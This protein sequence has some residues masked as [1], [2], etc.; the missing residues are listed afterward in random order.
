MKAKEA[1]I[2]IEYCTNQYNEELMNWPFVYAGMSAASDV[3]YLNKMPLN[4][5]YFSALYDFISMW[6][7][8]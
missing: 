5:E 1:N 4:W 8:H 2:M 6:Q 3:G 7:S